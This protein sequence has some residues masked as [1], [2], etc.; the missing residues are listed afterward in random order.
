MHVVSG[1]S[2]GS[3][4]SITTTDLLGGRGTNSGDCTSSFGGTSAAA[5][6]VAGIVALILQKNPNLGWRDVQGVL[7]QSA[8]RLAPSDSDWQTNGAGFRV[9]H[10]FGFGLVDATAA[11]NLAGIW[12][13]YGVQ[14]TSS[15][16]V[17]D[18]HPIPEVGVYNS[19]ANITS[20]FT[21]E[22]A[23]VRLVANHPRRGEIVVSLI[24]PSGTVSRLQEKHND[25]TA[26]IDW[27]Y[28]TIFNWGESSAGDWTL[29][30]SDTS[31]RNTGYL[32]SWTLTLYG[33]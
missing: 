11:V 30:V 26:N 3:T 22:H 25:Q 20:S 7:I 28:G 2:S 23:T 32:V 16:S 17:Q 8:A 4:Y 12:S 27:T 6:L 33:H 9:N 1:P 31:E 19:Y 24:S 13:N 29:Q 5:P 10:K 14:V 15:A 18:S 21:M